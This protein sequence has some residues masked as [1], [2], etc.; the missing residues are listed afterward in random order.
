MATCL[1]I[2]NHNLVFVKQIQMSIENNLDE[3]D[4]HLLENLASQ[5]ADKLNIKTPLAKKA[6]RLMLFN[7]KVL[8][9]KQ[10]DY[11]SAN[12]HKFGE[13]GVLV[14]TSDKVERLIN[15]HAK[16]GNKGFPP[17]STQVKESMQDTW[18]DGANYC[19]IGAVLNSGETF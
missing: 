5:V 13:Y 3:E 11:G 2:Q 17:D 19:F 10:Q 1:S 14:R 6:A 18:L 9:N 15:L 4:Q 16:A 12:L 8:D 7:L